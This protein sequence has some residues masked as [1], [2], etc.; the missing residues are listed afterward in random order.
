MGWMEGWIGD[1]GVKGKGGKGI[2]DSPKW[3]FVCV[4][5]RVLISRIR[6]RA[7]NA[8]RVEGRKEGRKEGWKEVFFFFFFCEFCASRRLDMES[9]ALIRVCTISVPIFLVL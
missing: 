7:A 6:S 4:H 3:V 2:D 1:E 5:V 8:D 9:Y